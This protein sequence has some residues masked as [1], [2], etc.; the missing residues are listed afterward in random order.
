MNARGASSLGLAVAGFS[1][2]LV[3]VFASVF[4]LA[5]LPYYRS[6]SW[7]ETTCRV[8]DNRVQEVKDADGGSSWEARISWEYEVEGVQFSLVGADPEVFGVAY[9]EREAEAV[10]ARYHV[11]T[12]VAC[13][14]DPAEPQRSVLDRKPPPLLAVVFGVAIA[15]A[16]LVNVCVLLVL[17]LRRRR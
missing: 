8:T 3:L 2:L 5:S 7:S 1:L 11:G 17:L 10:A 16:L 15:I 12:D 13:F 9:D 4:V 6:R 14:Y